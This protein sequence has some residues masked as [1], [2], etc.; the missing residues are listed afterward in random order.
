MIT[1]IHIKEDG[2]GTTQTED[3]A[4]RIMMMKRDSDGSQVVPVGVYTIDYDGYTEIWD[5]KRELFD[6][7]EAGKL[8]PAAYRELCDM[9]GAVVFW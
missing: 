7:R 5:A 6:W 4:C 3:G 9:A 2:V 8:S 1:T